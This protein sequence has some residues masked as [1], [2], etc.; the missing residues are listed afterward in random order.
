VGI[1]DFA[2]KLVGRV[3]KVT[4]PPVGAVVK[5][6]E[7]A[8]TLHADGKAIDMIAPVDGTVTAINPAGA[9]ALV[10]DPYGKGWLLKVESPKLGVALKNL[11]SGLLAKA[12]TEQSVDALVARAGG[13]LGAMAA[14]GGAPVSGMAK[15]LDP[16]HWDRIAKECFLTNE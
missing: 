7:R 6:G 15:N 4:L 3:E 10:D 5:Q 9:A 16:A 14:D 12:W 8:W 11:L 2:S 13:Q 1:D